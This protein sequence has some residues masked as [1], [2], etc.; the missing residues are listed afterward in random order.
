MLNNTR[1]QAPR[2]LAPT[3]N[4]MQC[5]YHWLCLQPYPVL[6]LHG[7]VQTEPGWNALQA[8]IS[9]NKGVNF[10]EFLRQSMEPWM[11]E[12]LTPCFS[13]FFTLTV[14]SKPPKARIHPFVNT[15]TSFLAPISSFC[16]LPPW[17]S[18]FWI[19]VTYMLRVQKNQCNRKSN[20][21]KAA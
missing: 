19:Y 9:L 6:I 21:G 2:A 13:L 14:T 20:G 12:S 17:F 3:H 1:S 4:L 8:T 7:C 5:I 10:W 18:V 11:V 16:V 15:V